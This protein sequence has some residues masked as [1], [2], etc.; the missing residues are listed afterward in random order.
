MPARS[1]KPSEP[2]PWTVLRHGPLQK[3]EP[4]LWNVDAAIPDMPLQRRMVVIR[5]ADGRL[6]I[7]NAVCLDESS[8]AELEALGT[9]AYLIVPCAWHR[10]DCHAWAERY[11]QVRVISPAPA[12]KRVQQVVRVDGD[13]TA[14]PVTDDFRCEPLDGV[15]A[16]EGVFL[17]RSGG[18]LTAIFNDALMNNP[19]GQ[20]MWWWLYRL[21]GST[22]GPKVTALFKLAGV[23][24]RQRYRAHLERLASLPDLHRMIP[25][26][27]LIVE[28]PGASEAIRTAAASL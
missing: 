6:V 26:H 1:S 5:L 18:H 17:V 19:H 28:G 12:R 27:G 10:L 2:R 20:G 7:H 24:D 9:P 22:G 16:G 13:Y 4:N 11:P 25:G 21:A 15:K 23:S 3:L 8:M 14:L